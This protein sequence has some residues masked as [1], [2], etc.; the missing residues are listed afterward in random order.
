MVLFEVALSKE[1]NQLAFVLHKRPYRETSLLVTLLT[2]SQGKVNAIVR[3]VRSHSK[4]AKLKQAWLQPFQGLKIHWREKSHPT[5]DLISLNY[6]EPASVRFPLM[7]DSSICGLYINELSYR[8]I[9]P[10]LVSEALFEVYQQTLLDLARSTDR[11]VQAWCLR[12]FEYQLLSEMGY[13]IDL[14][15]DSQN[16][17]IDSEISYVF[18][19]EMGWIPEKEAFFDS[20]IRVQGECLLKFIRQEYCPDC[21]TSLKQLFRF[22]LHPHLGEK[23]IQARALFQHAANSTS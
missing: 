10:S 19:S 4:S 16:R 14:S 12:R 5:S 20:G 1:I 3:G 8:L 9:Y 13:G 17:D 7:G 22:L 2:E 23:P 15:V 11:N 18:H 21:L 6:F